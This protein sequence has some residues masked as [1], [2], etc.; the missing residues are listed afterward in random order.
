MRDYTTQTDEELRQG[1]VNGIPPKTPTLTT[2]IERVFFNGTKNHARGKS[3]N[4]VVSYFPIEDNPSLDEI[5]QHL[6]GT[7]VLGSYT[8]ISGNKVNWICLDV[9]SSDLAKARNI[10]TAIVEKLQESGANPVVEF[11]GN[12]GYH[13]WLFLDKPVDAARA[14]AFGIKVRTAVG[15]P[16]SGDPHVEVF[17]KQ[18]KLSDSSPLGN[19]V[20]LPLGIHPKT[21]KRSAFCN[22]GSWESEPIENPLPLLLQRVDLDVIEDAIEENAPIKRLT[23]LLAPFWV[24]GE[25]H[26][27]ALCLSGYLATLGWTIDDTMELIECL[28]DEAG[29]DNPDNLR[30]CVTTTYS[31]LADNKSVKGFSG[32]SEKLPLSVMRSLSHVAGQ[33]IANSVVQSIDRIRLEK[34][35]ASFLKVRAVANLLVAH[36]MENGRFV[37][38]TGL[39]ER[40]FWFEHAQHRLVELRSVDWT[41][42]LYSLGLNAAESFTSQV[43][44]A[45]YQEARKRSNVAKVYNKFHWDGDRLW[46]NFGGPE[47]YILDG[48][49]IT[50]SYNGEQDVLFDSADA[51]ETFTG[52]NLLECEWRCPWDYLTK[53]LNF[54]KKDNVTQAEAEQQEH[55]LRA[56]ILARCFPELHQTRPITLLLG[57]R[58]S[59]KTTAARRILRFFNGMDADVLSMVDDKQDSLRSSL[60]GRELLALDNLEGCQ[61]RWLPDVLSRASTGSNIELKKLYKTNE[62]YAFRALC[63]FLIS[64][65]S[66]PKIFDTGADEAVASRLLPIQL[67]SR[68]ASKA[69]NMV[70]QVFADNHKIMWAGMLKYLNLC[71]VSLKAHKSDREQEAKIRLADYANFC[72]RLRDLPAHILNYRWIEKGIEGL[73]SKQ[74][75]VMGANSPVLAALEIWATQSTADQIVSGSNVD[76]TKWCTSGDWLKVLKPIAD[77]NGFGREQ[78]RWN[79]PSSLGRHLG[80]LTEALKHRFDL[81]IREVETGKGR[82]KKT[83]QP[84]TRKEYKLTI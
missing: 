31:R 12:K 66:I 3:E 48:E 23:K 44:E 40:L 20:K 58:G 80:L 84:L 13:I 70:Q 54:T 8:L 49:Q 82:D 26:D 28:V 6:E 21:K 35:S 62:K 16:T 50:L 53:D 34:G 27:L 69:E 30:E 76:L 29:A 10:A 65:V 39:N 52:E 2:A 46:V 1:R 15:A 9:D 59:G 36:F 63:F 41:S 73:G 57:E 64:A 72:Y 74:N 24:S 33:N 42:Q 7:L 19:L 67:E 51:I 81:E 77:R 78:W 45:L 55:M 43:T 17:P 75:E 79:E 38:T 83:G 11:S 47:V 37:K 61:A 60:E 25:R 56:L 71:V 22:V 4:G 14:K 32:L 68:V 5:E 18:E